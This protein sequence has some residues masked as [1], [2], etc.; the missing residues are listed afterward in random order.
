MKGSWSTVACTLVFL[1]V[2]LVCEGIAAAEQ[3]SSTPEGRKAE[4][5][6]R[7][8]ELEIR[9]LIQ[10]KR[11]FPSWLTGFLGFLAGIA[12]TGATVWVAHRARVGALDQAVHEKRLESYP[13][14]VNKTAPLALYFPPAESVGPD[15][16]RAMGEGM[17]DWYFTGGGLLMSTEARDAYFILARALTGASLSE[18]LSMPV[19]PQDANHISVHEVDN[20]R[21]DLAE[22]DLDDVEKWSFGVSVSG[23]DGSAFRFKDFVFL[24][25]L[26]SALRTELCADLHSRRRPS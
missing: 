23:S 4:L 19:F 5:E 17:R 13:D 9:E 8:L 14:L 22:L 3:Q 7:K 18:G 20:Y 10:R 1:G 21:R 15:D 24:Q 11:E 2:L 12:G 26:S 16:C 6:V 25:R